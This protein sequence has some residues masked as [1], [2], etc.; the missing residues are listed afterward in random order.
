[1]KT[2]P[3]IGEG[4]IVDEVRG[5]RVREASPRS[6]C[7]N[8]RSDCVVGHVT[9][10]TGRARKIKCRR[11]ILFLYPKDLVDLSLAVIW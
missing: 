1:M 11:S 10:G 5:G 8:G 2:Y 6:W 9:L 4:F 7:L 3:H